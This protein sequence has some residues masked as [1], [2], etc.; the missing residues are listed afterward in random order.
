MVF[1][2]GTK[3]IVLPHIGLSLFLPVEVR[4]G[5]NNNIFVLMDRM[6][7]LCEPQGVVVLQRSFDASIQCM[8][9]PRYVSL[10]RAL[11]NCSSR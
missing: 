6:V 3:T 10:G 9:L 8:V 4:K 2:N 11:V 5:V 1:P 7:C